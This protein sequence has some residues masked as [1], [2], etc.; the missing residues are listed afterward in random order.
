[1]ATKSILKNV[2]IRDNNS[3]Q[4]LARALENAGIR[5]DKAVD[6]GHAVSE[7]SRDE[8]RHMFGK[9]D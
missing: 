7:A 1:M 3:A 8:I 9:K 5:R 4:R 2:T 6:M